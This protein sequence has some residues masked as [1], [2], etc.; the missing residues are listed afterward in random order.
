D[1]HLPAADAVEGRSRRVPQLHRL[2]ERDVLLLAGP[3]EKARVDPDHRAVRGRQD[4]RPRIG[5]EID[6][7]MDPR[8]VIA[9]RSGKKVEVS[10]ELGTLDRQGEAAVETAIASGAPI[11]DIETERGRGCRDR[12]V[13]RT[14][15][16]RAIGG[17]RRR[18][19]GSGRG[20][21]PERYGNERENHP[22]H[23][24]KV[25]ARP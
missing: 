22:A 12:R 23:H 25:P 8:A 10:W 2:E 13:A 14:G 5:G 17:A 6:P 21:P 11:S 15:D 9:R 3:V 16:G 7:L 20:R 18:D 4:G 24:P 1:P 19:R